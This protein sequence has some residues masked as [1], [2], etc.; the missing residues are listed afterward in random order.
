[1]ADHMQSSTDHYDTMACTPERVSLTCCD[2]VDVLEVHWLLSE[3]SNTALSGAA[4]WLEDEVACMQ[5]PATSRGGAICSMLGSPI[6]SMSTAEEPGTSGVACI[7]RP[8]TAALA[9]V[10][11]CY[12]TTPLSRRPVTCIARS[13]VRQLLPVVLLLHLPSVHVHIA[14]QMGIACSTK[15]HWPCCRHAREA[16]AATNTGKRGMRKTR[17]IQDQNG[18]N[19]TAELHI[20]HC[21]CPG[22]RSHLTVARALQ[23]CCKHWPSTTAFSCSDSL[24]ACWA[25]ARLAR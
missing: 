22:L 3:A 25:A 12:M 4:G 24:A 5:Y 14:V 7:S 6:W 10:P 20:D 2:V 18:Y 23:L 21:K 15:C 19:G 8:P 17:F 11:S 9:E 13:C 1:M 16:P